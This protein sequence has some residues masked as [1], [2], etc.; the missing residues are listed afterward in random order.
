MQRRRRR[1]LLVSIGLALGVGVVLSWLLTLELFSTALVASTAFLFKVR[2]GA[3]ARSTVIVG[4]DRHSLDALAPTYGAFTEWPRTVYA[5]A[6]D[7]IMQAR[8]RVVVFD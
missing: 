3:H 6:L 2:T 8:P 1:R 5:S 7:S 4:V